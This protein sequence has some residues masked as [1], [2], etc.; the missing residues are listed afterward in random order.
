M[1][2][3]ILFLLFLI[4][5]GFAIVLASHK[6]EKE[7]PYSF[8]K[9]LKSE[10]PTVIMPAINVKQL[11]AEDEIDKQFPDIP[12]RFGYAIDVDLNLN[13]AGKWT[14]LQNGDR[15]WH[16]NIKSRGAYSINLVYN[17]FW[18]PPGSKFY[19][20]SE[21]RSYVLGPFDYRHNKESRAFATSLVRGE[22]IIL[23]YYEPR[24]YIGQGVINIS[25]VIHGYKDLFK[26]I[27]IQ[28]FNDSANC[29]VNINCP[30]GA[31]WQNEKKAVALIVVNNVRICTGTLINNVREDGTPY[32]LTAQH[33]LAGNLDI[34]NFHFDYE[35]PVCN[36]SQ[37]FTLNQSIV[38]ADTIAQ[39]IDTDFLLL[40]LHQRPQEDYD[41]YYAGWSREDVLPISTSCIHHPKGDV[42]KI[43][44]D[45][46]PPEITDWVT[47]DPDDTDLPFGSHLKTTP[48]EVGTTEEASS[49]AP[50][51]DQNKR[52]VGQLHGCLN[53]Q[54]VPE[55]VETPYC[56]E[57]F[58]IAWFGRF[59][60]SWDHGGSPTERLKD[61]LDPDNTGEPILD[62]FY[63][64]GD[65]DD[66]DCP[67]NPPEEKRIKFNNPVAG[68][69]WIKGIYGEIEYTLPAGF[70]GGS[71]KVEL[72]CGTTSGVIRNII[73]SEWGEPK[74]DW[75]WAPS[76]LL[77]GTNIIPGS[78]KIHLISNQD[79]R[80]RGV[81]ESF[82]IVDNNINISS[83]SADNTLN[84]GE[85]FRIVYTPP[86]VSGPIKFCLYKDGTPYLSSV[87]E[88]SFYNDG[89]R[90]WV[91][92]TLLDGTPI[93]PGDNYQIELS[94]C[95]YPDIKGMSAEFTIFDP[96]P[97]VITV[98]SPNGGENWVVGSSHNITWTSQGIAGNI[99]LKL[100]VNGVDQ[101]RIFA[102]P[103]PITNGSYTWTIG[104]NLPNG[105][106]IVPG[107]NFQVMVRYTSEINDLSNS[108][109]TISDSV[110]PTITVTNPSS[111][112]IW[113]H[114]EA[115]Q[116]TWAKQGTMHDWVKIRLMQGSTK[117]LG[118]SDDTANDGQ[119]SWTIPTS[120]STGNYYIRVKTIDNLVEGNGPSFTIVSNAKVS[121]PINGTV[122]YK[123]E[124]NPIMWNP[125]EFPGHIRIWLFKGNQQYK[126]GVID[127]VIDN[128]GHYAWTIDTLYLYGEDIEPG[129]NYKLLVI[130]TTDTT[131]WGFSG[132]FSIV[133][134]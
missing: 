74:T 25:K 64:S 6:R 61:W 83:P 50:M 60:W 32:L 132:T 108:S 99:T 68:Q 54:E 101:G 110:T 111:G 67:D 124:S 14:V 51:F 37:D 16:L 75:S 87:V 58:R 22:S 45:F 91:V 103:I 106:T 13:N 17:D 46:Q 26:R 131:K 104:N 62:G 40:K 52:I 127:G 81:S 80:Y 129:T 114:G 125:A 100:Y 79:I 42:K 39:N 12:W 27:A 90:N 134:R 123:N 66:P 28:D 113:R 56:D 8:D 109:F 126:S 88:N 33:C 117:I 47:N 92:D 44:I 128:D 118:I 23:E 24:D 3:K 86:V 98:S 57:D 48:Y 130:S 49:G 115:R 71:L 94:C 15:I 2:K 120:I 96:R 20:Y 1:K 93:E 105:Y 84:I 116:I 10:I 82:N 18:L 53:N 38:G 121:Y 43:S 133:Q 59:W 72:V 69:N 95:D 30:E 65:E 63:P 122:F 89:D 97:P 78:Y 112:V 11:L 76:A 31:E 41:V 36:P 7:E 34:W 19:V 9:D 55:G 29:E 85:N 73:D 77:D 35:S 119:F 4:W 107:S 5:F 21:V 102:D 70:P